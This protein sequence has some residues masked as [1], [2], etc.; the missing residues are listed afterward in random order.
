M[1]NLEIKRFTSKMLGA[2][3]YV[4]YSK[5]QGVII[6]PSTK[7]D[8]VKE[9]CMIKNIKIELIV[10]T[11]C[12]IDHTLYL[13]E[14]IREFDAPFAIHK[15]GNKGN[16]NMFLN[17]S[18]LFGMKKSFKTADVILNDGDTINIGEKTINIMW[19]PGHSEGSICIYSQNI[20][21]SGDTLFHLSIGRSDLPGGNSNILNDSLKT[22][23]NLPDETIV[24]PGHGG[25]TTIK[26]EK[27][28]NPYLMI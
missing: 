17:G 12:H 25:F 16:M 7:V 9:F 8:I 3:T 2:N 20:L 15:E 5:T 14:Y 22:L 21:I 1:D 11:H 18:Q 23:M 13:N 19:T 10:L 26:Y 27:E 6:D 28:N 24:Y 4:L